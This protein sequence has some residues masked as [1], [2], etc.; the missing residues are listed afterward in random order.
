MSW[1]WSL[2]INRLVGSFL[3]FI[4]A[5]LLFSS[6]EQQCH[7]SHA[8]GYF[9]KVILYPLSSLS[10]PLM[11]SQRFLI[12]Q[13]QYVVRRVGDFPCPSKLFN[14]HYANDEVEAHLST[15]SLFSSA[16]KYYLVLKPVFINHMLSTLVVS[17]QLELL[18]L[19]FLDVK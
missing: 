16:L 1:L 7:I 8:E 19:K 17:L 10:S 9:N 12:K 2:V 15:S 13:P 5:H 11:S 14:L 3:V 4:L 18:L 6:M